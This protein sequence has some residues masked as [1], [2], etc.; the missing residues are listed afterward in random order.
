M[1]TV[2]DMDSYEIE[3]DDTAAEEYGD[4]VMYAEWTPV[5]TQVNESHV[6]EVDKH[7]AFLPE[8]AR[9]D[10]EAFLEKVYRNQR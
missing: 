6:G 1:T 8:L 9:L 10:I 4:E 2:M 5:L 3:R 7:D